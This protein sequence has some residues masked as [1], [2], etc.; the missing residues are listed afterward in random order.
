MKKSIF[1]LLVLAIVLTALCLSACG[2]VTTTPL[3]G[4]ENSDT[5]DVSNTDSKIEISISEQVLVDEK[6][7][8]ITA[9]AFEK[10]DIFGDGISLLIE[11]SSDK[12]VTVS[13]E[14]LIINNYKMTGF[15]AE[16]VASGMKS[17]ETLNFTSSELKKAGITDVGLIEISFRVYDS[18]SYDN[19]FTSDYAEIKTNAYDSMKIVKQDSGKE[20]VNKDGVRIVGRFIEED[21]FW[22]TAVALFIENTGDKDV[23]VTVDDLAVNGFMI[24]SAM[25]EDVPAGKMNMGDITL[26]E[27]D[28]EENNI[29][30]IETIT[31]KFR[32]VNAKTLDTLYTT[33][34][35]TIN[36]KE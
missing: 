19:I 36:A 26:L 14:S 17:N 28:L 15:L 21:T 25:Y 35:I 2:E 4:A 18:E 10:D 9:T 16:T 1:G 8:K 23:Y 24:D 34:T 32:V 13:C 7:V 29:T 5:A 30:E 27:S 12:S 11:N 33:D 3:G 31:L 22:G 20:L 6:G